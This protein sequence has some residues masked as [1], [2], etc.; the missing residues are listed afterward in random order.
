MIS[1]TG[2]NDEIIR[3]ARLVGLENDL[4]KRTLPFGFVDFLQSTRWGTP[5]KIL[6]LPYVYLNVKMLQNVKAMCGKAETTRI[7][8]GFQPF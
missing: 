1:K 6:L 2:V 8:G 5:C 3:V 4:S 7:K